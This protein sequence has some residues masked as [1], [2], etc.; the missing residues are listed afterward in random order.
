MK[1]YLF[2]AVAILMMTGNTMTAQ[3]E[4]VP[5]QRKAP[6]TEEQMIQKR[7][8]RMAKM[9][10]LDDATS[11][12]FATVYGDYL[13]E[14]MECRK[15]GKEMRGQDGMKMVNKSDAEIDEMIKNQ[16]A[17]GHKMININEK[18]FPKFRQILTAQQ[19]LKLFQSERGMKGNMKGNAGKGHKGGMPNGNMR[20]QGNA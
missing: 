18:Y 6:Q 9:L 7:T 19:V 16:F 5:E 2:L 17:Q 14:K 10:M 20:Q 1:K 15:D 3:T 11:A 4:N 12:K 13:K 8:E